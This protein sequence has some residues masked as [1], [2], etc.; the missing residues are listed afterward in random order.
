MARR[1]GPGP[2]VSVSVNVPVGCTRRPRTVDPLQPVP[3]GTSERSE[4]SASASRP[5]TRSRTPTSSRATTSAAESTDPHARGAHFVAPGVSHHRGHRLRELSE[6]DRSTSTSPTSSPTRQERTAPT[7]SCQGDGRD[8]QGGD[9]DLCERDKQYL[10]AVRPEKSALVLES[11]LFADEVRDPRQ[12]ITCCRSRRP[13]RTAR[14]K[15][16]SCSSTR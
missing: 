4:T 11:L 7:S 6:I 15:W 9:R 8:E 16:P 13:L 14:S 1:S 5:A 10:V 3:A 12:E 2:S